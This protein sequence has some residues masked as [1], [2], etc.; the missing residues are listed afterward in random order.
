MGHK[1][2]KRRWSHLR[3]LFFTGGWVLA[4]SLAGCVTPH[5]PVGGKAADAEVAV[6]STSSAP[7]PPAD[8]TTRADSGPGLHPLRGGAS[9]P[10]DKP[11][12]AVA[13]VIL[14]P[15][16]NQAE[17]SFD[18]RA[19]QPGEF[20]RGGASWYGLRFHHKR[21]ASGELF[22]MGAFT[23]AHR[24]LPFGTMVCVRSLTSDKT[25]MVKVNDRGPYSSGRIIDLSR[26]AADALGMAGLGIKQVALSLPL[27]ESDNCDR[28]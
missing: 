19:I 8:S 7:Q 1:R 4:A 16:D 22:D 3:W 6:E 18:P 20:A 23:A 17:E 10:I 2:L 9:T 24:T 27:P 21:T 15:S 28:P 5:K 13:L 12:S 26:A 14:E 25:V 11:S